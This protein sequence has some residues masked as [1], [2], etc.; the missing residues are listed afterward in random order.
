MEEK[1]KRLIAQIVEFAA[2]F[3]LAVFL[4]KLATA[5]ITEIWW[6]LLIL[7][8]IGVGGVIGWRLWKNKGQW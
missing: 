2:L 5:W 3:A 6:I 4:I 7:A 1:P 8:V